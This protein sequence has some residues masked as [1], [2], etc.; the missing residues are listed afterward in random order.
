MLQEPHELFERTSFSEHSFLKSRQFN[1]PLPFWHVIT[2]VMDS[3]S[4][5]AIWG[6]RRTSQWIVIK[7]GTTLSRSAAKSGNF[8]SIEAAP[9]VAQA[10][11]F[12]IGI[13]WL[14]MSSSTG[15]NT[16]DPLESVSRVSTNNSNMEDSGN[17]NIEVDDMAKWKLAFDAVCIL[18][19][20]CWIILATTLF[21]EIRYSFQLICSSKYY[22]EFHGL[23]LCPRRGLSG[24]YF[25]WLT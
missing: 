17:D 4:I 5:S 20:N 16:Q 19:S 23:A 1:E 9:S 6:Y 10:I 2:V 24:L 21:N 18:L 15:R 25:I 8:P 11:I 22:V 12:F 3:L 13:P 14:F 7:E